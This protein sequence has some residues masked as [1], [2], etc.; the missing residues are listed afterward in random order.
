MKYCAAC[1]TYDAAAYNDMNSCSLSAAAKAL[2]RSGRTAQLAALMQRHPW[3]LAP[4]ALDVMSALP[5]T[6]PARQL[7]PLLQ[8]VRRHCYLTILC[9]TS[10]T[11]FV[12][13]H[14]L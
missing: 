3:S 12:R 1:R 5:E 7:S 8:Q 6:L 13:P 14:C 2:A 11:L 9:C 4:H 10:I